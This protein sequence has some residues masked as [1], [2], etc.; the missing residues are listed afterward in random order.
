[1]GEFTILCVIAVV[2]A[3]LIKTFLVQAFF[4]PSGSMENTLQIKDRILV[5]KLVYDFRAPHR[6]D[7]VVF[8]GPPSWQPEVST[9]SGGN[10]FS[11]FFHD[12][13]SVIGISAP[14]DEDFV[15][16]VIGVA[17]DHVVCCDARGRITVNGAPLTE[18]YLQP[19]NAPSE[20]PF[21]VVVPPGRLWVMGDHRDDSADSRFH[22]DDGHEG[23]IPVAD[24]IG[25]A[26]VL[27][28]PINRWATFGTPSTFHH[29]P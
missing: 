19:G 1:M 25:R 8:K 11:R 18:P 23:T 13:G 22:L 9:S 16:R 4:I 12:I 5:N 2:L 17:G 28:W 20:T 7:I 15:K 27:V 10:A 26:S 6:G 29:V 3:L 24:V 14:S 21:N